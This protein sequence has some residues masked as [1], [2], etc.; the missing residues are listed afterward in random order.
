VTISASSI[1]RISFATVAALILLVV[2]Q[3]AG[4][5]SA[6]TLNVDGADGGCNDGTGTPY[7]TISGAVG[8]AAAGDTINVFPGTYPENVELNGMS[9]PGDISLTTVNATGTPTASTATISPSSGIAIAA[10]SPDFPGDIFISG[11]TVL[12]PTWG[13]DIRATGLVTLVDVTANNNGEDGANI[14]AGGDV[15]ISGS[16]ANGNGSAGF[17]LDSDGDVMVT[18]STANDNGSEGF[19]IDASGVVDITGSAANNNAND[20]GEDG[21]NIQAGGNVIIDNST[22]SGNDDNDGA[23]DPEEDGFHIETSGDVLVLGSSADANADDGFRI[24]TFGGGSNV[25]ITDS[26]ASD[27]LDDDGFEIDAIDITITNATANNDGD[28]GFELDAGGDVILVRVTANN[29]DNDGVG[30]ECF[31]PAGCDLVNSIDVQFSVFIGN[32]RSGVDFDG[33]GDN[34]ELDGTYAVN[35]SIICQNTTAGF[36]QNS[37]IDTDATANWWGHASG[38]EHPNNATPGTGDKVLDGVN[39]TDDDDPG[40]PTAGMTDFVP[41]IDTIAGSGGAAT[42]GQ[43]LVVTFE[44]TGDAPAALFQWPGASN[45]TLAAFSNLPNRDPT[46]T[47][48]TDNGTVLTSGFILNGTLEVALI[49]EN[50]GTATV[51]VTGPCGLGGMTGVLDVAAAPV[52]ATPTATPAQLPTSGGE[53]T[54]GGGLNAALLAL[55]ALALMGMVSGLWLAHQRRP[56][57]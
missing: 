24:D 48:T 2:S 50:E 46:F 3:S 6:A 13:I 7:C 51:T 41:W 36:S 39:P 8:D 22:T 53:P 17:E 56:T 15:T 9:V 55:T 21:F 19:E 45:E 26:N 32:G 18:D 43:P 49:P 35:S 11:F 44:F 52:A 42:Q 57:R 37:D 12:S 47:A 20:P 31:E 23:T 27:N 1:F 34:H 29:N 30:I 54:D 4:S 14:R 10:F 25:T 40:A 5:V 38:P 28:E 33:D 16:T